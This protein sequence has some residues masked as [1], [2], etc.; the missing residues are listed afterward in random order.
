MTRTYISNPISGWLLVA[1]WWLKHR[2]NMF[3]PFHPPKNIR[4]S[5]DM[6]GWWHWWHSLFFVEI[7]KCSKPPSSVGM[8]CHEPLRPQVEPRLPLM[9]CSR[10]SRRRI[11]LV[12]ACAW[13]F[14]SQCWHHCSIRTTFQSNHHGIRS[15]AVVLLDRGLQPGK[16]SRLLVLRLSWWVSRQRLRWVRSGCR[17]ASS[18]AAEGAVSATSVSASSGTP[19]PQ[20][21]L[22]VFCGQPP[23]PWMAHRM[24]CSKSE[25]Q[26]WTYTRTNIGEW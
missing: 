4:I 22:R 13:R 20:S 3:Q 11:H 16:K 26:Q 9:A 19:A 7:E 21:A 14:F 8:V 10:F 2:F 18:A 23:G 24:N 12:A 5:W 15:F 6:L 1:A 17:F 25:A